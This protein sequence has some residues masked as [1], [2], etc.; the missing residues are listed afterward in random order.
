MLDIFNQMN[1]II[2][3]ER[4]ICEHIYDKSVKYSI[5]NIMYEDDYAYISIKVIKENQL[6]KNTNKLYNWTCD[7]NIKVLI[8]TLQPL[9]SYKSIELS[10][11]NILLTKFDSKQVV[12]DSK[13]I[14]EVQLVL[15]SKI[16]S[17][18]KLYCSVTSNC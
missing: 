10:N 15:N 8:K 6:S 13:Y 18:I 9:L 16:Y 12:T 14:D 1:P 3:F 11:R 17:T 2:D 4:L 5:N 7:L